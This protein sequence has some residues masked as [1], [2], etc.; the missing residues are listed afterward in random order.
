MG[1]FKKE[2][3]TLSDHQKVFMDNNW[4]NYTFIN[5]FWF[6]WRINAIKKYLGPL[7]KP[8]FKILDIG[9]GN[10]LVMKQFQNNLNIIIDG[11]DLNK[12]ALTNHIRPLSGNLFLYNILDENPQLKGKYDTLLLLDVIEHIENEAEFLT[13]VKEHLKKDGLVV[14]NVPALNWLYSK[15]DSKLGHFRRYNKKELN[16]IIENAGFRILSSNYWGF[17]LIPLLII[18]K[19]VL[20]LTPQKKIVKTGFNMTSGFLN[21]VFILLMK[22]ELFLLKNSPAGTSLLLVAKRKG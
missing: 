12:E 2:I 6:I 3:I 8:H 15:Y 13:S 1:E 5:H 22:I 19:M 4:Y 20:L 21:K 10:G 9:C 18:R 16:V 7:I 17:F 11:C 14:I